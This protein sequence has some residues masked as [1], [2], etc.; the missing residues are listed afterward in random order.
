M[1]FFFYIF[2]TVLDGPFSKKAYVNSC[3]EHLAENVH[4]ALSDPVLY[5]GS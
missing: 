1:T 3:Y 4:F 5:L 2:V